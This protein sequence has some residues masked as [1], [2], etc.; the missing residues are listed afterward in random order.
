[1]FLFLL[2]FILI[3]ILVFILYIFVKLLKAF[4][5]IHDR[6]RYNY[7]FNNYNNILF[8]LN[9]KN[10]VLNLILVLFFGSG[11]LLVFLLIFA[12]VVN[13]LIFKFI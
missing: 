7:N 1:M 12:L 9:F 10:V 3:F 11:I 13:F 4:I 8:D 5:S 6:I 2:I